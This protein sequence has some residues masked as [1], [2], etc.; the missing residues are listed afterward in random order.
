MIFSRRWYGALATLVFLFLILLNVLKVQDE[1]ARQFG[2]S[3]SVPM[4]ALDQMVRGYTPEKVFQVMTSY[5]ESGRRAYAVLLLTIDLVF[6]FLYGSF[7]FFSIRAASTKA[8][9]PMTSATG[10]AGFGYCATCCDWLENFAFLRLMKIY[11]SQFAALVKL[12]SGFTVMKFVFSGCSLAILSA[13]GVL[14]L[15]R[16][17]KRGVENPK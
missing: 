7:L 13:L 5:G 15:F 6:P 2:Y 11:P 12:A 9:I 16:A 1:V 14:L 17:R 3:G 10:M 8:G 4:F